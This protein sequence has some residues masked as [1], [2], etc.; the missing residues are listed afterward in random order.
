MY[1]LKPCA[2]CPFLNVEDNHFSFPLERAK[3]I[4]DTDSFICHKTTSKPLPK[5]KQ[6]AGHILMT[7]GQNLAYRVIKMTNGKMPTSTRPIFTKKEFV[8]HV[9]KNERR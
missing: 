3:E 8:K 5:R 4:A 2:N 6:C 1:C 7:K 9:T